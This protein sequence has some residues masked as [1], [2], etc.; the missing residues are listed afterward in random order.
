LEGLRQFGDRG[1]PLRK[2]REDGASGRIRQGPERAVQPFGDVHYSILRL[3]KW[4]VNYSSRA[5][6]VK[7]GGRGRLLSPRAHRGCAGSDRCGGTSR[8]ARWSADSQTP[9]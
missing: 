2:T 7:G 9:T 8:D 1:L 3:I 5:W 6:A 4:T